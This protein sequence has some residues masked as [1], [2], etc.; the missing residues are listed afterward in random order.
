MK[1]KFLLALGLAL[2][3]TLCVSAALAD[4]VAE[5]GETGYDTID[6]SSEASNY[7]GAIVRLT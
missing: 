2:A 7:S 4:T 1:K 3:L 6:A 5:I